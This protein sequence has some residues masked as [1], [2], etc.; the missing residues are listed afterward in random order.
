ME[1]HDDGVPRP[2]LPL[3]TTFP[4]AGVYDIEAEHAGT[5][6]TSQ[7]QVYPVDEVDQPLVGSELPAAQAATPD[8]T[9]D[10]DPISTPAPQCPLHDVNLADVVEIVTWPGFWKMARTYWRSGCSEIVGSIS[11]ELFVRRARAYVP[12]VKARDVVPAPAGVRAQAISRAGALVDDFVLTRR[13]PIVAVRNAPS[14]AAT[15]FLAIAEH[16]CRYVTADH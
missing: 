11:K 5:R 12:D 2:Y 6:M 8:R 13:G 9:F 10:V 14:Q 3:Y 4:R 15:S 7:V 1:P 16:V